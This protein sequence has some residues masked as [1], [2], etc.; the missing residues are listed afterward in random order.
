MGLVE[1]GGWIMRP[2]TPEEVEAAQKMINRGDG[3]YYRITNR[4]DLNSHIIWFWD[5]KMGWHITT[6]SDR[7]K[8]T[9]WS[10]FTPASM[11]SAD[12][13]QY[14]EISPIHWLP[15]MRVGAGL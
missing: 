15:E 14:E 8:L 2:R 13:G 12:G 7:L 11:R 5:G 1:S 9:S 6:T 4:S 3:R 10:E